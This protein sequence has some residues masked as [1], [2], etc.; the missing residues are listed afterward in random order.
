M[1]EINR[2]TSNTIR[3]AALQI[4][5]QPISI[6]DRLFRI[7]QMLMDV[8]ELGAELVVLP[9]LFN[10]GLTFSQDNFRH[11]EPIEA[12]D[13]AHA[14]SPTL[15]WMKRTAHRYGV[16]LAGSLL[17]RE[18]GHVF[19][20][21]CLCAPDGQIWF[22]HQ[23]HPWGWWAGYYHAGTESAPAHSPVA[24]TTIGDLGLMVGWD[25]VYPAAWQALAQQV[26]LVVWS[27]AP[28]QINGAVFEL[29]TDTHI[30]YDR[31]GKTWKQLAQEEQRVHTQWISKQIEWL[32]APL[33]SSCASGVFESPLPRS[34]ELLFSC[35]AEAPGLLRYLPQAG[36]MKLQTRL[37]GTTQI[38]GADGKTQAQVDASQAE[39][40]ALSEAFLPAAKPNPRLPQPAAPLSAASIRLMDQQL[41][42]ILRSLYQSGLQKNHP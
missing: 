25:L 13:N 14:S 1:G 6:S 38:L 26:D 7:D 29:S 17:V 39:G 5:A 23:V 19:N 40:Y 4:N 37:S 20:S 41:P 31:L 8:V 32:G 27:S 16:H 30:A 33:V 18:K 11:A 12:S 15:F 42:A 9:E 22:R 2:M 21:L 3:A 35:L 24:H 34:R 28:I 10:T 36:T